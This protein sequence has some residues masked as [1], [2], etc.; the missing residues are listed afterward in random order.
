[1]FG[2]FNAD[3]G[4]NGVYSYGRKYKNHP[5]TLNMEYEVDVDEIGAV[6]DVGGTFLV[7]YRDG[8]TYGVKATDPNNKAIGV[9][10]GL[11]FKSPGKRVQ[12]ITN[13]KM[14]E[15]QFDK[16]PNGTSIEFWYRVDKT[17]EFVQAECDNGQMTFATA[18][19]QSAVFLIGADGKRY[20]PRV[21]VN[22][23]G[24]YTP[25]VYSIRTFFN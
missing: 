12:N 11:D 24:N 18:N 23:F 8:A 22:P 17:G 25:E 4:Y 9:Y 5:F 10:E 13:Y 3:S 1:M 7:S 15:L 20:E 2:V 14:A 21:V 19:K 6:V 16:L